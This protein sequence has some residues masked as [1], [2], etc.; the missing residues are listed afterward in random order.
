MHDDIIYKGKYIWNRL[1]NEKNKRDHHI[2]FEEAVDVFDELF[3]VE[4]YDTD[5]SDYEDRYHI[6]GFIKGLPYVTVAFMIRDNLA[7]IFSARDADPEEKE[8]YNENVRR[9][10]GNR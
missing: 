9:H 8:A 1:K 6:I 4:E 5:N 2:S 7:R 3:A 10:I